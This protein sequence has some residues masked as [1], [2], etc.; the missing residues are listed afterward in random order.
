M[1]RPLRRNPTN[2]VYSPP[3]SE[4]GLRPVRMGGP[5]C[6]YKNID[7]RED[8]IPLLYPD[9]LATDQFHVSKIAKKV[10]AAPKRQIGEADALR[11]S[12]ALLLGAP[13]SKQQLEAAI[14]TTSRDIAAYARE[15]R[16]SLFGSASIMPPTSPQKMLERCRRHQRSSSNGARRLRANRR[17]R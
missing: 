12:R 17:S 1:V 10:N 2:K 6:V 13:G 9:F 4:S 7:S 16:R 5:N 3:S 15:S 8:Q 14:S 11:P